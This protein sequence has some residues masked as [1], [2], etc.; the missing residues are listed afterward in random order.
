MVIELAK[1]QYRILNAPAPSHWQIVIM[2]AS[3]MISVLAF[4]M[5]G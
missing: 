5:L 1:N 2:L 3:I 4:V